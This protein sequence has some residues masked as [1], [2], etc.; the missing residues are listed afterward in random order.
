MCIEHF[1]FMC[2]VLLTC[3]YLILNITVKR[4]FLNM[5]DVFHTATGTTVFLEKSTFIDNYQ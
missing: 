3:F 2:I 1:L 5:Q 4:K